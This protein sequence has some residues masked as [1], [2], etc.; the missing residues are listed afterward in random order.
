MKTYNQYNESVRDMM[1]PKSEEEIM[2]AIKHQSPEKILDIGFR[3]NVPTLVK[4]ALEQGLNPDYETD[5]GTPYFPLACSNGYFEIVKIFIE[6]GADINIKG[7]RDRTPLIE[8]TLEEHIEIV[9]YL[10]ENGADPNLQDDIGETALMYSR[11]IEITKILLNNGAN[12]NIKDKYGRVAV[13]YVEE[14]YKNTELVRLLKNHTKTNESVRD[15]MK[16]KSDEDIDKVLDKK[17]KWGET[18]WV[19]AA[20]MWINGS[21]HMKKQIEM[22]CKKVNG[23]DALQRMVNNL[24]EEFKL[25]ESVRDN[26]KPKS[27]EDIFDKTKNLSADDKV[28]KGSEYGIT[29]LIKQGL[30]EGANINRI[31]PITGK[32]TLTIAINK[33]NLEVIDFLIDNRVDIN[34]GDGHSANPLV[35]AGMNGQVDLIKLFLDKGADINAVSSINWTSLMYAICFGHYDAAKYLLDNGA[36]INVKGN[37]GYTALTATKSSKMFDLIKQHMKTNESVRDLLK[38]KSEEDIIKSLKNMN[39]DEKL[40]VGV[41]NNI[42]WIVKQALEEGATVS[43]HNMNKAGTLDDLNIYYIMSKHLN[44]H[45][46]KDFDYYDNLHKNMKRNE[47]VR[48]FLKPKS[49]EDIKKLMDKYVNVYPKLGTFDPGSFGLTMDVKQSTPT[50]GDFIL[51]DEKNNHWHMTLSDWNGK[52]SIRLAAHAPNFL[53]FRREFLKFNSFDELENYLISIGYKKI[54][55]EK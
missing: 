5:R 37:D 22:R 30:E 52:Y 21:E 16:P 19:D 39:P 29:A 45:N 50:V 17:F 28:S 1:K 13:D 7:I 42:E 4:Y 26:M 49:K 41:D 10:L 2:D 20:R 14:L 15:H 34:K 23:L 6:Y 47:S 3:K 25:T 33:H 46:T 32:T 53:I 18:T 55:S 24:G 51:V 27:E 54:D 44:R 12:P 9:K 35:E 48:D 38:P 8:A 11:N 31:N 43:C 40:K 36:D